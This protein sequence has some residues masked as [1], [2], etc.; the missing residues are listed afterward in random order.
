MGYPV[1]MVRALFYW[2]Q[3]R[4]HVRR[5][6]AGPPSRSARRGAYGRALCAAALFAGILAMHVTPAF[7]NMGAQ[8][9]STAPA[10]VHTSAVVPTPSA[11]I[12]GDPSCA[13]GFCCG[14]ATHPCVV[15]RAN[16]VTVGVPPLLDLGTAPRLDRRSVAS[17]APSGSGS[18]P[19]WTV[20]SLPELSVLRV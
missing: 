10:G 16:A 8:H 1:G 19:P 7:L 2:R 20:L 12:V 14:G 18:S 9:N 15:V 3:S 6:G 11:D 4:P 17:G 13:H 5:A